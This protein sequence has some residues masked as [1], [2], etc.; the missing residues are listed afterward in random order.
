MEHKGEF[1]FKLNNF[2][3]KRKNFFSTVSHV[4]HHLVPSLANGEFTEKTFLIN[5]L[6][7]SETINYFSFILIILDQ[8]APAVSCISECAAQL[9]EY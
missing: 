3:N 8:N 6:C 4:L 2:L 5:S 7:S 1:F 9:H